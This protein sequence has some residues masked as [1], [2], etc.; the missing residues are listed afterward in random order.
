MHMQKITVIGPFIQ[1]IEWKQTDGQM[2]RQTDTTDRI[3]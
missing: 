2:E 1:T 3:C